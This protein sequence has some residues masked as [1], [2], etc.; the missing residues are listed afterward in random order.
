M[1]D[2]FRPG[3]DQRQVFFERFGTYAG[4]TVTFG[5]K[6]AEQAVKVFV[7]TFLPSTIFFDNLTLFCNIPVDNTAL[8]C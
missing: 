3:V 5:I 2:F 8:L 7:C 1:E 6:L 4:K